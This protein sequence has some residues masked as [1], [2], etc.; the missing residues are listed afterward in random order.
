MAIVPQ[1]DLP[2]ALPKKK[3]NLV[4]MDDLPTD[5]SEIQKTYAASEVPLAAAKSFLPSAGQAI[6]N[7]VGAVTSPK[8]SFENL[9]Q[10]TSGG[11][12]NLMPEGMQKSTQERMQNFAVNAQNKSK[13][14]L[15]LAEKAEASGNFDLSKKYQKFA[16]DEFKNRPKDPL[17]PET[18]RRDPVSFISKK[19]TESFQDAKFLP[20]VMNIVR[21]DFKNKRDIYVF[22]TDDVV[23]FNDVGN[24]QVLDAVKY[25]NSLFC[26]SVFGL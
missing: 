25:G 6:S 26:G 13:E 9:M 8:E 17:R 24:N 3:Q 11:L 23:T 15:D 12:Y 20:T 2:F 22:T 21:N 1:E 18:T 5:L 7:I 19:V 10:A 14:Y 16:A 4:P